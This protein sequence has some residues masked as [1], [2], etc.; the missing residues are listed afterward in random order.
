VTNIPDNASVRYLTNEDYENE[1]LVVCSARV[2][3]KKR[4]HTCKYCIT[5]TVFL[6]S[7]LTTTCSNMSRQKQL[8]VLNKQVSTT[9]IYPPKF[10]EDTSIYINLSREG[11]PLKALKSTSGVHY[12]Q[13][14]L[15]INI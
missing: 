13:K 8:L 6:S 1:F 3:D 15:H 5:G 2:G 14:D 11:L 4:R 12:T 10:P 7:K 9:S